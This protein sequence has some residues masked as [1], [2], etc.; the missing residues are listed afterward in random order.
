MLDAAATESVVDAV[1]NGF[2][3]EVG[4][5]DVVDAATRAEA[6]W[7]IAENNLTTREITEDARSAGGLNHF[8][9]ARC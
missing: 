2:A 7:A 4:F 5:G 6:I 1:F 3:G 9:V 8:R